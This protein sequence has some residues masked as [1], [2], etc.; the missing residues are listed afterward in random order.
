V[1]TKKDFCLVIFLV[2]AR[3]KSGKSVFFFQFFQFSKTSCIFFNPH[4]FNFVTIQ[5]LFYVHFFQPF[6]YWLH[7]IKS[8]P[9]FFSFALFFRSRN[10]LKIAKRKF[11][12]RFI[13]LSCLKMSK[14][15]AIIQEVNS[16]GKVTNKLVP[17]WVNSILD[18]QKLFLCA[19]G[20]GICSFEVASFLFN[21]CIVRHCTFLNYSV[22]QWRTKFIFFY[23]NFKFFAKLNKAHF[24]KLCFSF[25]YTFSASSWICRN[26]N[27]KKNLANKEIS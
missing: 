17:G 24:K 19:V 20:R 16:R 18:F 3:F 7:F 4:V 9:N 8:A 14:C 5:K 26:L 11:W 2:H 10:R 6:S 1:A 23:K 22:A 13:S 25:F 27:W 21:Y 15:L 12:N